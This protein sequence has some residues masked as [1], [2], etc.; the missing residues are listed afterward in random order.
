MRDKV[1]PPEEIGS[2]LETIRKGK[3]V[4]SLNGSFD[5]MHAGHLYQIHEAKK[6]GDILVVCLNSDSSIQQYK[7]INRPI[8]P[9][10]YRLQMMSALE[11]V[12]VVTYFDE[13]DPCEILTKVKPDVHVNG[14]EY[15]KECIEAKTVKKL[16]AR[17]HLVDLIDGLSTS[18]IIKK[19]K[20]ES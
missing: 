3:T 4:V 15:G 17:L 14:V 13:L 18:N 16:G 2:Y 10:K 6:Q 1:I 8:I 5:L 20:C 9:L 7:S 11:A 12:D 19:I